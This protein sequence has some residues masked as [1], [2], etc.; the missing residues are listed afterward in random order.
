MVIV[1]TIALSTMLCNDL[2]MPVLLRLP[3]LRLNQRPD[4][5]RLLLTI[6]RGS[7]LAMLLMGYAYFRVV[8]ES[9]ALVATGL[10]SFAAVAQFAPP[11]L[12]GL[13]WQGATLGGALIGLCAGFA[14]WLYTLLLPAL[15]GSGWLDGAFVTEGAFGVALLRPDALFG[16]SGLDPVSHA[17]IWSLL[18]N[19]CGLVGWSLFGRQGSFER[20]QASLF[21]QVDRL[22]GGLHRWRGRAAVADLRALLARYVGA[23][24]AE[25]ALRRSCP[26]ARP[27]ADRRRPGRRRPDRFRRAPAGR[28]DRRRLGPDHDLDR[29]QGRRPRRRPGAGDP[30]RGIAGDRVQP[31]L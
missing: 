5:T 16:L 20:I 31:A 26:R 13:Y 7:I 17:L 6:R 18:V 4:L 8:G 25:A 10:I 27:G 24:R 2:I 21:V 9:I 12:I 29:G 30:R 14:V 22:G 1:E 28:R 19:I 3:W 11:I 15:A 23:E